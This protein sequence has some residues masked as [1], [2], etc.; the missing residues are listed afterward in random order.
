MKR[1][2]IMG[3]LQL[4]I[5]FIPLL[6]LAGSAT[7]AAEPCGPKKVTLIAHDDG[8]GKGENDGEGIT[9]IQIHPDTVRVVIGCSFT[10][11][12]PG[13]HVISTTST[14]AWLK[15]PTPTTGDISMG[16]AE[17]KKGDVL[18]YTIHVDGI[19]QLDPRARLK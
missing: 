7:L 8:K 15:K 1:R 10:L 5:L 9:V 19:G 13:N 18:K 2:T 6:I 3:K 12:N 11:L 4:T 17:G 16:P 14:H